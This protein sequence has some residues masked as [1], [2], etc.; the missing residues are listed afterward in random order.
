M[1]YGEYVT[2]KI[3]I[4]IYVRLSKS[5]KNP[6]AVNNLQNA[7]QFTS[8]QLN[9]PHMNNATSKCCQQLYIKPDQLQQRHQSDHISS[10]ITRVYS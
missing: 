8:K 6:G 10:Q 2:R 9:K 3:W 1:V 4:Y 7:E 5:H